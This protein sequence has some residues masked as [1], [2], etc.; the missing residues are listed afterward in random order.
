MAN[1][2][3]LKDIYKTFTDGKKTFNAVENRVRFLESSVFL[4]PENLHLCE[5]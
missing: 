4:V 2:I 5:Q 3:E 1:I